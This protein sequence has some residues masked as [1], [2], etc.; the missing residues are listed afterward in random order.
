[1]THKLWTKV[2]IEEFKNDF[3][4]LSIL[5]LQNKYQRKE[6][7]I[8]SKASDLKIKREI[9]W[10]TQELTD[11]KKLYPYSDWDILKKKLKR[12]M[13]S[14]RGKASVEN[15]KRLAKRKLNNKAENSPVWKGDNVKYGGIHKW[16][17]EHK[18][19]PLLCEYCK[20]QKKLSLANIKGHKYTRK[21]EDYKWLCYKCHS[22]LDLNKEFCIKGHKLDKNNLI[23][24]SRG[25]RD[26]KICKS[27]RDKKYR[28]K[29]KSIKNTKP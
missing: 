29:I 18:S 7:N 22:I 9:T 15:I 14:I 16:I 26:C 12:T 27:R 4:K 2:E 3:P 17:R 20:K 5:E 13:S 25:H 8:R 21:I 24:T 6:K 19:K 23:I 28:D 11:L 10:T 1:M